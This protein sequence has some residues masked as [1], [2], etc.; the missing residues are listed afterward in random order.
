MTTSRPFCA[1]KVSG[2]AQEMIRVHFPLSWQRPE[3]QYTS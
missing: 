2:W 3:W 1:L